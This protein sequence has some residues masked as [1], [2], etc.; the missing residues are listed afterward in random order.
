[1]THTLRNAHRDLVAVCGL[2]A[3]ARADRAFVPRVAPPLAIFAPY[4]CAKPAEPSALANLSGPRILIAGP[5]EHLTADTDA[6]GAVV[7]DLAAQ[8]LGATTSCIFQCQP[9]SAGDRLVLFARVSVVR[10]RRGL[11]FGDVVVD[12]IACVR[13]AFL[14][15]RGAGPSGRHVRRI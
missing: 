1:M 14:R 9:D 6:D 8:D 5:R 12:R 11:G 3:R 4:K 10:E 15:G 2:L 7:R 13:R